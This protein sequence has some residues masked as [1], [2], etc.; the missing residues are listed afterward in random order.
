MLDRAELVQVQV[1]ECKK[2]GK[3]LQL[4]IIIT[5]TAQLNENIPASVNHV[6]I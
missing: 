1:T 6:C 2:Y 5:T 3:A 4:V